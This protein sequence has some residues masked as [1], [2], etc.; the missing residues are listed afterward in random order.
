[1]QTAL[2]CIW[3]YKPPRDMQKLFLLAFCA[4]LFL[5]LLLFSGTYE[6]TNTHNFAHFLPIRH[7]KCCAYAS[8]HFRPFP[9]FQLFFTDGRCALDI[10]KSH[11]NSFVFCRLFLSTTFLRPFL[12]MP[13]LTGFF[14]LGSRIEWG[15]APS[16]IKSAYTIRFGKVHQYQH[17]KNMENS[18]RSTRSSPMWTLACVNFMRPIDKLTL[19][20]SAYQATQNKMLSVE[21]CI[22][23]IYLQ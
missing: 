21:M 8:L 4:F 10:Q 3:T 12:L 9:S 15:W 11:T 16:L 7:P 2:G 23:Y 13:S 6:D 22:L 20:F 5:C 19:I 18:S 17:M 14:V 1:M